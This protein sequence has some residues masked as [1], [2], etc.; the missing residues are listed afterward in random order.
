MTARVMEAFA[1]IREDTV[2]IAHGGVIAAI[3]EHLFPEENKYRYEWQPQNGKGYC[4]KNGTYFA[5]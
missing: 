4:L 5:L 1:E 2:L 3:M